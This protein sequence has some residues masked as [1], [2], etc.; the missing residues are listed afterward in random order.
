MLNTICAM[1]YSA[2]PNLGW[3]LF[4]DVSGWDSFSPLNVMLLF[5]CVYSLV[6][7]Y[8]FGHPTYWRKSYYSS[9]LNLLGGQQESRAISR[10]AHAARVLD[11]INTDL[12]I[13]VLGYL[14]AYELTQVRQVSRKYDKAAQ[15]NQLWDD[16]GSLVVESSC[17]NSSIR[18]VAACPI[19]RYFC[20]LE[21]IM[22]VLLS[23]EAKL[24]VK[25]N[26][27][28]FDLTQFAAEHPGGN[29]V[30]VEYRGRDA[31]R[32]FDLASHSAFARETSRNLILF[33]PAVYKGARGVPQIVK[34]KLQ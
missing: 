34:I 8:S 24:I 11:T 3:V 20:N 2:V 6:V 21:R 15:C 10:K 32:I 29:E 5:L 25:L 9:Q 23:D 27:T 12:L 13:R 33:D 26:G 14:D 4:P 16:L 30:L 18:S 1:A 22:I 17:L 28:L 31:T 7:N 19:V